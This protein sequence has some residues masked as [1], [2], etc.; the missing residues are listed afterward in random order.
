M[1]TKKWLLLS[2]IL[3]IAGAVFCSV[4]Y[5]KAQAMGPEIQTE[6]TLTPKEFRLN[7]DGLE[8]LQIDLIS[9]KVSCVSTRGQEIVIKYSDNEEKPLYRI[10]KSGDALIVEY[11]DDHQVG[12]INI[13]NIGKWFRN[14]FKNTQTAEFTI[15]IPEAY[16]GSADFILTSGSL[17]LTGLA[18]KNGLSID[19]TS[20]KTVLKDITVSEGSLDINTTSGDVSIE[21]CSVLKGS[22]ATTAGHINIDCVSSSVSLD[23]VTADSNLDINTTSGDSKLKNVTVGG[24]IL[25]DQVSGSITGNDIIAESMDLNTTSGKIDLDVVEIHSGFRSD[26]ISGNVKVCFTDSADNYRIETDTI[27]GKKDFGGETGN[28]KADKNI[29]IDTTSGN[30]TLGFN[31]KSSTTR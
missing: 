22:E 14:N 11:N 8:A 13:F 6:R 25:A 1:K 29:S 7:S 17:S 19:K 9:E 20:G 27:S 10:K 15:E 26:S 16:S 18:F 3:F 24:H 28:S 5:I 12:F 21:R 2:A 31:A 4:G 30:I 23:T